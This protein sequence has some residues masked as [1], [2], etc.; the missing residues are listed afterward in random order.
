MF[1]GYCHS[2]YVTIDF[3]SLTVLLGDADENGAVTP[4][5]A[6]MILQNSVGKI[7]FTAKQYYACNVDFVGEVTMADAL[8]VLQMSA[9]VIDG[10]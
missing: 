5:D 9:G 8:M 2:D 7:E 6:L 4:S 10:F 3:N 1:D